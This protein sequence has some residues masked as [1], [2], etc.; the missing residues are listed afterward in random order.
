MKEI[1]TKHGWRVVEVNNCSPCGMKERWVKGDNM[2]YSITIAINK[3]ISSIHN[4][5]NIKHYGNIIKRGTIETFEEAI[6]AIKVEA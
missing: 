4:T 6:T 2:Y 5:Y 3:N 1:L